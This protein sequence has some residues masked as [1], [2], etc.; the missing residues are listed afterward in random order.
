VLPTFKSGLVLRQLKTVAERA[1]TFCVASRN[2]EALTKTKSCLTTN[3]EQWNCVKH[4]KIIMQQQKSQKI[5]SWCKQTTVIVKAKDNASNKS[6][7]VVLQTLVTSG[8]AH[9]FTEAD[10]LPA[11]K[12]AMVKA[13]CASQPSK[14]HLR[15]T[16]QPTGCRRL[17]TR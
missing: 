5:V 12:T 17:S 3:H 11:K 13:P 7:T 15:P 14:N 2:G 6:S 4:T 16:Q 9:K 8:C 1:L 10:G